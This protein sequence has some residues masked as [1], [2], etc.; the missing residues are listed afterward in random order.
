MNI[1]AEVTYGREAGFER[2][3]C[4]ADANQ[5]AVLDVAAN[6]LEARAHLLVIAEDVHVRVDES[7]Q[8]ELALEIDQ[9]RAGR[10][11]HVTV[12]NRL[13]ASAPHDDRGRATG[14]LARPIEQRTSMNIEDRFSDRRT[15]R[16]L[17][18][19]RCDHTEKR[20]RQAK[21]EAFHGRSLY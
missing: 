2:A 18:R 6:R 16:A 15:R 11:R 17:L 4:V 19:R 13:D 1:R 14:S 7:R 12:A 10:G 8:V 3:S 5:Q 21:R 20:D 9:P